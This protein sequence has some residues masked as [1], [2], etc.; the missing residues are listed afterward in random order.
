MG[1]GA[2][3]ACTPPSFTANPVA[4]AP[5]GMLI[6][7]T[8]FTT[9]GTYVGT[10]VVVTYQWLRDGV[11]I[12]GA[13]ANSYVLT[14]A[15]IGPLIT[16][17]V[18]LTG[19][20]GV[21]SA[22]GNDLQW[23]LSLLSPQ[24]WWRNE[25]LVVGVGANWPDSGTEGAGLTPGFANNP[26]NGIP[27]NGRATA[28][29]TGL[30]SF[31]NLVTSMP[32][33]AMRE[34]WFIGRPIQPLTP[35]TQLALDGS[36][37]VGR[38][39]LFINTTDGC[40][41]NAGSSLT[42]AGAFRDGSVTIIRVTLDGAGNGSIYVVTDA[43]AS[44]IVPAQSGVIG[45]GIWTGITV[46]SGN[47]GANAWRG[48]YVELVRFPTVLSAAN[49]QQTAAFFLSKFPACSQRSLAPSFLATPGDSFTQGFNGVTT[50]HGWRETVFSS[51]ED[52]PLAN[53]TQLLFRGTVADL[54]LEHSGVSGDTISQVAARVPSIAV[55][56]P[57]PAVI[58][59][60]PLGTNDCQSGAFVL[61]AAVADWTN[62]LALY[63]AT[64]P[65]VP[66]VAAGP[67]PMTN[68][69]HNANAAALR[70]ALP[71]VFAAAPQTVIQ[72]DFSSFDPA[73]QSVDGV[74]PTQAAYISYFAPL[75]E[76]GIRLA[77]P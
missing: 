6:G 1:G 22:D 67:P 20:C 11:P 51:I 5:T 18:T 7:E 47:T 21:A 74:H 52:N 30:A 27:V 23:S 16:P 3:F 36:G 58:V 64:W 9:D 8:V 42:A 34:F 70:A 49:A 48:D 56:V 29:F 53:N 31:K 76:E 55:A 17:R 77:L 19:S 24:N 44:A 73:T 40:V 43:G 60:A 59:T 65:G 71:A 61:A 26:I 33:A 25:D 54:C 4:T 37:G 69:T 57:N 32:A 50:I 66:V 15:D 14:A 13:I 28:D 68:P 2:S 75:I 38:Q 10:G 41:A 35:A 62:L 63:D 72:R 45:N 39:T 12:G 46:G